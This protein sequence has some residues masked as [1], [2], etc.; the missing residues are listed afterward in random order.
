VHKFVVCPRS[1]FLRGATKKN[2]FQEGREGIVTV[3]ENPR[4]VGAVIECLY[5]GTYHKSMRAFLGADDG[6]TMNSV[7]NTPDVLPFLIEVEVMRLSFTRA[8][9]VPDLHPS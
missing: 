9:T 3:Y 6:I 1:E 8:N 4:V 7:V 2:T 5:T